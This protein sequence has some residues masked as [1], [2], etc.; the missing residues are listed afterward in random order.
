MRILIDLPDEDIAWLDAR[1]RETSKSRA[2]LV[3]EAVSAYRQRDEKVG[4]EK[5]FGLWAR[6]GSTVD[7][8]AYERALRD[9]WPD[10]DALTPI[11][12]SDAA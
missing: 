3:R 7:G 9:E 1:A 5:Y 8:L 6:C 2:A 4:F 10:V 12:R 11:S